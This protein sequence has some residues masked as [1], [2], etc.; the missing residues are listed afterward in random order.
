LNLEKSEFNIPSIKHKYI[1]EAAHACYATVTTACNL[2]ALGTVGS[3][4][5]DL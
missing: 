3:V 1:R 2:Q 4:S 5:E